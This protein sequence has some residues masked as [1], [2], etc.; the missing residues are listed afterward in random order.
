MVAVTV[1]KYITLVADV[2]CNFDI[3]YAVGPAPCDKRMPFTLKPPP[4]RRTSA[5]VQAIWEWLTI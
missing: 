3:L 1:A 5:H 2:K 4:I